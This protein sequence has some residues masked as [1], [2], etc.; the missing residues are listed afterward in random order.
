[1]LRCRPAV[2]E[3]LTACLTALVRSCLCRQEQNAKRSVATTAGREKQEGKDGKN[4]FAPAPLLR[5]GAGRGKRGERFRTENCIFFCS[6]YS[7][8][9]IYQNWGSAPS[10]ARSFLTQKKHLFIDKIANIYN[11]IKRTYFFVASIHKKIKEYI[12]L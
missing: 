9:K 12:A 3:R 8:K 10:P 1:M 2:A 11:V 7:Q 4:S 6:K 5:S